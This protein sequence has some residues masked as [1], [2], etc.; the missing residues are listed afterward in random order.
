VIITI[1]NEPPHPLGEPGAVEEFTYQA[2]AED[3][4]TGLPQRRPS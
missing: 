4:E 1:D 2:L 3:E